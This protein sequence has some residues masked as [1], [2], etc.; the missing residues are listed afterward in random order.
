M[1]GDGEESKAEFDDAA[2]ALADEDRGNQASVRADTISAGIS[3][4]SSDEAD[5]IAPVV[6]DP[7]LTRNEEFR[8]R[9]LDF[10]DNNKFIV[11]MNIFVLFIVVASGAGECSLPQFRVYFQ[12][13]YNIQQS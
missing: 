10:L 5:N 8:D 13:N 2:N 6:L 11:F 12:T 9:L 4:D 1:T 7:P 3:H